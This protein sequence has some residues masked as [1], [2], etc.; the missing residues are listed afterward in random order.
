MSYSTCRVYCA[1]EAVLLKAPC[2]S[3]Q[4]C[5]APRR[6]HQLQAEWQMIAPL[7]RNAHHGDT[8]KTQGL[9]VQTQVGTCGDRPPIDLDRPGPHGR[10]HAGSCRCEENVVSCE[11]RRDELT[12]ALAKAPRIRQP[13]GGHERPRDQAIAGSRIG[14]LL[15]R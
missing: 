4:C 6:S 15:L 1:R 3:K 13:V 10:R 7:E 2:K 9:R 12:E 14:R 5:F 8:G 11:E